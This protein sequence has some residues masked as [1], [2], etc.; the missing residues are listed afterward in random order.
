MRDEEPDGSRH[1]SKLLGTWPLRK[2]AYIAE[3]CV[4][5]LC[6]CMHGRDGTCFTINICYTDAS[7]ITFSFDGWVDDRDVSIMNRGIF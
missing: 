7:S 6:T 5:G 1:K 2:T 3:A 4:R